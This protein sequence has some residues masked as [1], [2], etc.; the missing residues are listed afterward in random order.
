MAIS[1][2]TR[3]PSV[4]TSPELLLEPKVTDRLPIPTTLTPAIPVIEK[5]PPFAAA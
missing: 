2:L 4:I 1:R 3:L 5:L